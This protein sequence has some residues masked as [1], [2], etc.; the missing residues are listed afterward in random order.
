[1]QKHKKVLVFTSIF[2]R[3][4]EFSANV[5][6]AAKFNENLPKLQLTSNLS[7]F[8]PLKICCAL[9]EGIKERPKM[10]HLF[11]GSTSLAL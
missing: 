1:M 8:C 3:Y 4:Y 5:T 2:K 11:A 6:I 9:M 7:D 10:K